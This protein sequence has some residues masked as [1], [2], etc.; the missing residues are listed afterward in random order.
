MCEC[1]CGGGVLALGEC[2]CGRGQLQLCECVWR[3][4][5]GAG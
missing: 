2:A 3:G 5:A 1:A 4:L